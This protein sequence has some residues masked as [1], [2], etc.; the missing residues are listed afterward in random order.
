MRKGVREA[1]ESLK[2]GPSVLIAPTGYGKTSSFHM[3]W[4]WVREEWGR[5][6]HVLPLR[7]LV[8]D[9]LTKALRGLRAG[10]LGYQAMTGK[11]R[12][13]TDGGEV[14]VRKSPFMTARYNVTTYDS[15]LTTLYVMPVAEFGRENCHWDAGFLMALSSLT[16]M[17]EAHVVVATEEVG[18]PGEEQEK[19]LA[20]IKRTLE[21]LVE[22]GRYPLVMTATLPCRIL[23]WLVGGLDGVKVHLCL[24]RRGAEYYRGL[25]SVVLHGLDR[26]FAQ[27]VDE[28]LERVKTEV[29]EGA[30]HEDVI[31]CLRSGMRRVLVVC[32]TVRRAVEVYDALRSNRGLEDCEV[33]LL[34]SRLVED[35]KARRLGRL[36]GLFSK[37]RPVVLVATQVVEAGVDY[38]F[39]ALVTEIAPPA[40]LIQ[41]AGRVVR[42]L[43][44]LDDGARGRI[45]VNASGS[46]I[47]SA[48]KVYPGV[49][50]DKTL[51]ALTRFG[52]DGFDWRFGEA[53][54]SFIGLL[55]VYDSLFSGVGA[56]YYEYVI[57]LESLLQRY[58]MA[59]ISGGR[60]LDLLDKFFG[61]SLLREAALVPLY[62]PGK[63]SIAVSLSFVKRR[64]GLL[65][66][67]NGRVKAVFR[68]LETDEITEK[69]VPLRALL[70]RPCSV[71]ARQLR[72][73]GAHELLGLR[74]REG[75]YDDERGLV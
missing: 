8:Y 57:L 42:R 23:S 54:K 16:V 66:V 75:A 25:R 6:I 55:G 11:V 74:L 9:V 40:S 32:N 31:S 62:A 69:E 43:D 68:S 71:F 15:Y 65:D 52:R 41:R 72:E 24:G 29:S 26:D 34:H 44:R 18:D 20:V 17:D 19:S 14:T 1:I 61:G 49:L 33:L 47:G 12:V 63:G 51:E 39:D 7:A 30:L 59:A 10:E 73:K 21:L 64:V 3:L 35:D 60:L 27:Y 46:S 38:D 70:G 28:Y 13:E 50:I 58:P 5:V 56:R 48:K 22:V 67:K 37:E 4:D 2:E 53:E 45:V 36:R